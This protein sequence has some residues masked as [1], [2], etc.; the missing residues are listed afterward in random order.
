[1]K[2]VSFG[3]SCAGRNSNLKN[4]TNQNMSYF[5]H[6][7]D[8]FV[9]H[10]SNNIFFGS[11]P[12]ANETRGIL[13]QNTKSFRTKVDDLHRKVIQDLS[14]EELTDSYNT[15]IKELQKTSHKK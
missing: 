13:E 9:K 2:E 12:I 5:R 4:V 8:V 1:M 11:A 15:F 6:K 14:W 3:L 10:V 7:N